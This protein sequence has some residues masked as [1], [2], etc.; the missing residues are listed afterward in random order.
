MGEKKKNARK[1]NE[2]EAEKLQL[3]YEQLMGYQQKIHM[4]NQKHIR[5]GI[6]CMVI[7]PLIF[8][9]LLFLSDSSKIVFLVLW[10]ASLFFIA[11]YLVVVEYIDYN[12]QQKIGEI[13]GKEKTEYDGLV[14]LS[15]MEQLGKK[16]GKNNEKNTA[17]FSD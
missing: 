7:I 11:V 5:I 10:I 8:L 9:V 1:I 16:G 12:L 17:G 15:R 4:Q 13:S 2:A 3:M 6:R 14:D